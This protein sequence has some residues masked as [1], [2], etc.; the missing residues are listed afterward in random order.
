MFFMACAVCPG[1][2]FSAEHREVEKSRSLALHDGVAGQAQ[3]LALVLSLVLWRWRMEYA[4]V[5]VEI[6]AI[7]N[8]ARRQ[9]EAISRGQLSTTP[10]HHCEM[11]EGTVTGLKSESLFGESAVRIPLRLMS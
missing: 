10:H 3:D 11:Y 6:F 9:L 4:S 2:A 1:K 8:P 7:L 5:S